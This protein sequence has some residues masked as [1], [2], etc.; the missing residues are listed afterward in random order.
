MV[1]HNGVFSSA[2][3]SRRINI[4]RV[5]GAQL[6]RERVRGEEKCEAHQPELHDL[7]F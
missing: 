7:F 4:Q 6:G 5:L 3:G 2:L 1:A